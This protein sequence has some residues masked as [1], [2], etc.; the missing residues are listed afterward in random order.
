MPGL[1]NACYRV[2]TQDPQCPVI[3]YRKFECKI[4]DKN[5]EA[6]IFRVASE[7]NIGPR[8]LYQNDDYRIESFINARPITIWEMRNPLF[9]KYYAEKIFSFNFN[10]ALNES[11]KQILPIDR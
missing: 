2:E 4:V 8:L 1:S 9:L 5:I 10:P 11:L 6:L 3:L 7:Q